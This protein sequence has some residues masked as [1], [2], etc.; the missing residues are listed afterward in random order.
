MT[1]RLGRQTTGTVPS[2]IHPWSTQ[3]WS[4]QSADSTLIR[5]GWAVMV[6]VRPW[7]STVKVRG[8][9][10]TVQID[11]PDQDTVLIDTGHVPA[12]GPA[13]QQEDGADGQ[14]GGGGQH[15]YPESRAFHSWIT[16][17]SRS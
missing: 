1:S 17:T 16:V 14:Q 12:P 13:A 5:P 8:A 15:A 7:N 2:E 11:L 6:L 4:G 10:E 9:E 3:T